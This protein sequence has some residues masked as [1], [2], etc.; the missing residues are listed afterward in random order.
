M[1]AA[2]RAIDLNTNFALGYF[3]LA[4]GTLYRGEPEEAL[5]AVDIALRLSPHDPQLFLWLALR[6]S[7]LYLLGR[8]QE[9]V[10]AAEESRSLRWFCR[11]PR[12]LAASYGQLGMLAEARRAVA[13][14]LARE[15]A[16]K[17]IADVICRFKR[18]ADRA[19]YAQGLR[20]AG[21]PEA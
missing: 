4:V 6:G 16:E 14:L 5:A 13:E 17:T 10:A 8:Y 18:A 11:A 2:R 1:R 9:A 15:P 3:A 19:H 21:L 7:A 20:K 12:V